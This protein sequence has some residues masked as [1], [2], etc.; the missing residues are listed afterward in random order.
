MAKES[1]SEDNKTTRGAQNHCLQH[2]LLWKG[3]VINHLCC[4]IYSKHKD[5][6]IIAITLLSLPKKPDNRS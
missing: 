1:L 2:A 6:N 5:I 3:E 4:N